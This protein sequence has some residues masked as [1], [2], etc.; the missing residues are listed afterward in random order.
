MLAIEVDG[1]KKFYGSLE[2][3]GG[4]DFTVEMG[5]CFG[6]LGP[7]GA[8][9]TTTLE[10]VEGLREPDGGTVSILG[11]TP[12]PRNPE[13][14]RLIGVQLQST[15]FIQSLNASEQLTTMCDIYDVPRSRSEELLELVGLT[16]LAGTDAMKLSGGQQQR[17][18]IALALVHRPR[19]LFLDEPSTGLDPGAR[20]SLWELLGTIRAD[21]TTVVLTTHYMEEAEVLCDRVAIMDHGRILAMDSP[22]ALVREL[23][24]PTSILLPPGAL[25]MEVAADLTGVESAFESPGALSL[26]TRD[27]AGVLTR[28]A[29]LEA[30][31]G[32]QVRSA[33]LE[34]VFVSLTGRQ[35]LDDEVRS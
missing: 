10:I 1:L 4:V 24:A 16:D 30:L 22:A 32:I 35:L 19:V 9:K 20:R 28:L 13:L 29:G 18:S 26:R 31:A 6:I 23:D 14:L 25:T 15:A 2:A 21:G 12:W 17:L 5:E 33:T 7:N 8:G 27:P 11:H 34:D 3:V